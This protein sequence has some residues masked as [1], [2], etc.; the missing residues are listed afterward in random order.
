MGILNLAIV[1]PQVC[2]A[3]WYFAIM[4]FVLFCTEAVSAI[5]SVSNLYC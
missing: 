1:M 3:L 2:I 4:F 5:S